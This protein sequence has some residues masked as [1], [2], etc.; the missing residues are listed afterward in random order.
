MTKASPEIEALAQQRLASDESAI[1]GP[2]RTKMSLGQAWAAFW[3]HPSPWMILAT[4]LGPG[5]ARGFIH[6]F[7]WTELIVP[8]LF[9]A[10][11]PVTEWVV[12]VV[13]LHW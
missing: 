6:R 4:V 12:H 8:V 10:F 11:F 7:S 1:T 3:R 2:R 5:V 9:V 13:V